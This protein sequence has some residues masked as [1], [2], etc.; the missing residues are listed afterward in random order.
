MKTNQLKQLIKEVLKEEY[1]HSTITAYNLLL[2]QLN[3]ISHNASVFARS[4]GIKDEAI[5]KEYQKIVTDLYIKVRDE[6]H[7][8][9]PQISLANDPRI[10][11]GTARDG[12]D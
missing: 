11:N 3:A 8:L 4:K 1:Q 9:I 7:K 5:I 12:L 2:P 6:Q 10:D